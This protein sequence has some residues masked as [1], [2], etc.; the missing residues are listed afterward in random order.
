VDQSE[1]APAVVGR[2]RAPEVVLV[3]RGRAGRTGE[4]EAAGAAP[5]GRGV[6]ME[7]AARILIVLLIAFAAGAIRYGS[8]VFHLRTAAFQLPSIAL[9]GALAFAG[10]RLGGWRG[11]ILL[12]YLVLIMEYV[13]LGSLG[14]RQ[15]WPALLWVFVVGL[16]LLGS[17]AAF[18]AMRPLM[19]FGRFIAVAILIGAGFVL[20]TILLA[21]FLDLRPLGP[22]I[23]INFAVGSLAGA[24]LGLGLEVGD[25]VISHLRRRA[26]AEG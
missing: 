25:L 22:S 13:V 10:H 2:R 19:G 7:E 11:G 21:L 18:R 15:G 5:A 14:H 20:A 26:R 23:R 6:L 12:A 4:E 24:A 8:D 16:S 17:I 1:E 3:G 9:A